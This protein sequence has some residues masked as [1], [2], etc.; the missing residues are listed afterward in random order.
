MI[1]H[2]YDP[3]IQIR[4]GCWYIFFTITIFLFFIFQIRGPSLT[5]AECHKRFP[6]TYPFIYW[7]WLSPARSQVLSF[8]S[9]DYFN[10]EFLLG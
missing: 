10:N 2:C 5:Y 1:P 3:L 4:A 7:T 6:F 8:I 9:F